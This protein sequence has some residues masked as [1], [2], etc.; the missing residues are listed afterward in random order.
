MQAYPQDSRRRP[1]SPDGAAAAEQTLIMRKAGIHYPGE[2][3]VLRHMQMRQYNGMSAT[4]VK[5]DTQK[6]VWDAMLFNKE[7]V[8]LRPQNIADSGEDFAPGDVVT[9]QGMQMTQYNGQEVTLYRYDPEK[10]VWDVLL[11][12][13]RFEVK[14]EN[15]V[16]QG[17]FDGIYDHVPWSGG[18]W[19][20]AAF[21]SPVVEFPNRLS[22][23]LMI[24]LLIVVP[25]TMF[26][27]VMFLFFMCYW[28]ACWL[29]WIA[30]GVG[31]ILSFVLLRLAWT[32]TRGN[33]R[34]WLILG[35][36]CI[37]A[38]GLGAYLGLVA[39][40]QYF[41]NEHIYNGSRTY[42]N[43]LPDQNPGKTADGESF[44][45]S[46]GTQVNTPDTVGYQ[47]RGTMYCVAPI[48]GVTSAVE[49]TYVGY[50]A[51]GE[52]CC[53]ARGAFSC[54]DIAND[55]ARS[56]L[57]ILDANAFKDPTTPK[58]MK[59]IEQ[60]EVLYN[61]QVP[62]NPTLVRWVLNVDDGI[63]LYNTNG[64]NFFL[65][66]SLIVLVCLGVFGLA[67]FL[68]RKR[69]INRAQSDPL[70]R[71]TNFK[72][73]ANRPANSSRQAKQQD[74]GATS[75]ELRPGQ[76]VRLQG[77]THDA[78]YNG[79]LGKLVKFEHERN[80]WD[81]MLADDMLGERRVAAKSENIVP[82][83]ALASAPDPTVAADMKFYPGQKIRLQN[84]PEPE[85]N[86]RVGMIE[87]HGEAS[88]SHLH[89]HYSVRLQDDDDHSF[90]DRLL[91]VQRG[92]IAP[93]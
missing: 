67:L 53:E 9:L 10:R 14:R 27:M 75:K 7:R 77:F 3:V 89:E 26:M 12:D 87:K 76:T 59:A 23:N 66:W 83:T 61:L 69:R 38:C 34:F 81:V 71:P 60:A 18:F 92:N 20:G 22:T 32:G 52:N 86:G 55:E 21:L 15:I 85:Y 25:W 5:Y 93:V 30:F 2:V 91:W 37:V 88:A 31:I 41:I 47:T 72:P 51:V 42:T 13:E 73:M 44:E 24:G 82:E 65:L 16:E 48:V 39:Y 4:L 70:D 46:I 45:F 17:W 54:G 19:S 58:Y 28:F 68:Y 62:S 36:L 40:Y 84:M 29:S 6:G 43:V 8:E 63:S 80:C 50:W 35:C 33:P 1:Q 56:G 64:N 79:K 11:G 78:A 49:Q 90:N 57:R 74:Y